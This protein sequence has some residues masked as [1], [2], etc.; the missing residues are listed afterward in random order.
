MDCL[1]IGFILGLAIELQ[2]YVDHDN[3]GCVVIDVMIGLE[4]L[5][6]KLSFSAYTIRSPSYSIK[7]IWK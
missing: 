4:S 7:H 6:F 2:L 5:I 1:G 3:T